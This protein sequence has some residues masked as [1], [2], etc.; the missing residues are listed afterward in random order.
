MH[1]PADST[2]KLDQLGNHSGKLT[3]NNHASMRIY[4]PRSA[5]I[6]SVTKKIIPSPHTTVM[7]FFINATSQNEGANFISKI[8]NL[9]LG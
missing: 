6:L 1:Q 8:D 4:C 3:S 2:A 5:W 9:N 7:I